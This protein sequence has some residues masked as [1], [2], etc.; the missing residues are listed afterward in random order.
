MQLPQQAGDCQSA[1]RRLLTK[2]GRI[3]TSVLAP[4]RVL[5]V[6][7]GVRLNAAYLDEEGAVPGVIFVVD[8]ATDSTVTASSE[9]G[10]RLIDKPDVE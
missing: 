9:G 8:L 7:M 6:C 4:S 5:Y 3:F 1:S 2:K 10:E